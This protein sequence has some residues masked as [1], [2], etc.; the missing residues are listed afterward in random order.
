MQK[1]ANAVVWVI[2][3]LIKAYQY[4]ISPLLGQCCRF[5]PSCS[6]YAQQAFNTHGLFKGLWLTTVRVAKC[7]PFH[8]GGYDPVPE[9]KTKHQRNCCHKSNH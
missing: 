3:R 5:E 6:V 4:L 7:G 9:N 8:P 2:Q 1:L